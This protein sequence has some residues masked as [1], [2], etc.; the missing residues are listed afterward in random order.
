MRSVVHSLGYEISLFRVVCK[1]FFDALYV[2][3][4]ANNL[5]LLELG[6]SIN[7]RNNN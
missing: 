6:P 3:T 7:N 5:Y 1:Y 2:Y 4:W